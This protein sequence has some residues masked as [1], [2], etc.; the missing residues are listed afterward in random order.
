MKKT[1]SLLLVGISIRLAPTAL[2]QS[3][4]VPFNS[5]TNTFLNVEDFDFAAQQMS[6]AHIDKRKLEKAKESPESKP[7]NEYPEGNWGPPSEGFRISLHFPKTNYTN[8]EPIEAVVLIRNISRQTISYLFEGPEWSLYFSARDGQNHL[9]KDLRPS[10]S[11]GLGGKELPVYP[12]TQRRLVLRLDGH[13]NFAVPG[14]YAVTVRAKVPNLRA[15]G[16]SDATSGT[17]TL[18]I[19]SSQ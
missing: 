14:D 8:G 18:K 16:E 12:S 13:F 17:A 3:V 7:E 19:G 11:W 4:E 10:E 6:S 9:V 2:A 15:Y 5:L 1:I